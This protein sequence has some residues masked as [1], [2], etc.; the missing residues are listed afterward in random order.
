MKYGSVCSG[1]EAATVAWH[2]LGWQPEWFAEIEKFPSQVLAHHYPETPNLG[3]MTEIAKKVKNNE[4]EAPDILVGGTPCQAFSVAGLRNSL[5]DDRGQLSLEFVRLANEIDSA[6]LIR[7]LEPT[8]IV[9]ENVPGVLNT[10]DN[11]FGC[12]LGALSGEGCELQPT[13]KKWPNA[14]CVFGPQRQ[15]AWR[16]LDAQYFGLAQRRK[17]VFVVAS[18]R[19]ECVAKILF[20]RK[21]MSGDIASRRSQKES[22]AR[23]GV[24]NT[25]NA[26]K[27]VSG[28]R[29]VPPLLASHGQK[30]WLG[31][32]EA[33]CGDYYIKH[34]IG[35][36][37]CNSN[38]TIIPE[39]SATLLSNNDRGYV[40]KIFGIQGNI[41]GRNINAGGNGIGFKEE[42]A[43]TLTSTDRHGVAL[44]GT[45]NDALRDLSVNIAPTC[46]SGGKGGGPIRHAV[47]EPAY[48]MIA[49]T[50]PKISKEINGTLR[51]SGGGGIVPS[52]VT[53]QSIARYLTEIECERLQ[54]F[55]DNYTG[56][57]G[58]SKSN[59][60]KAL[61]NSMAVPVMQWIG[62]RI[63]EFFAD[64]ES[65]GGGV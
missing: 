20:E 65:V 32:Q 48:A 58:A 22:T 18:A 59:R 47:F 19:T 23:S 17:R 26:S 64:V 49:D 33:F 21:S 31:N 45:F 27:T 28:K 4:V 50:T 60:Y 43:P 41:I 51:S 61:G 8:I 29:I 42:Q 30:M 11:A 5:D 35:V 34:A 63:N 54:G 38:A 52:S 62:K 46:R 3:D 37:G 7:G 55:P 16:V 24:S 53:Y 39:T 12:F 44:C 14:G 15:I 56:I 9:W 25:L 57:P 13:G 40:I 1:I 36:G 2:G 10:K 6:R